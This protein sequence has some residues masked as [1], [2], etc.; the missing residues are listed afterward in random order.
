MAGLGLEP[1]RLDLHLMPVTTDCEDD[2]RLLSSDEQA[3]ALRF[4]RVADRVLFI[5]AHGLLR[6]VLSRHAAVA[7]SEWQFAAGPWGKPALCP[8]RHPTLQD[9]RFNLS[10]CAGQVAV[11]VAW[12]REVGVDI[13]RVDALR[14]PGELVPSVLGP[15]EQQ[16]WQQ[17]GP[18][19]RA[20][21][22]F[23]MTRWTLKE[24][25]LKALGIGLTQV[26]P[27]QL[28]VLRTEDGT[29][30][31]IRP[32]AGHAA[33]LQDWSRHGWLHSELAGETHRW[34]LACDRRS[35]EAVS[36]RLIHHQGVLAGRGEDLSVG[37]GGVPGLGGVVEGRAR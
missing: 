16:G 34:A 15:L 1:G 10:H 4:R 7:P 31:Q 24:A 26:A 25:V 37:Q 33:A 35:G 36:W 11:A 19:L 28:E 3:R 5:Q 8:Q 30:W 18:D 13:E 29:G 9:L 21:Q 20:Q 6:R 2:R 12:A 23:L 32:C 17:V 14:Q 27:H 22:H